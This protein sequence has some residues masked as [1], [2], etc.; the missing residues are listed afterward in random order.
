[1]NSQ[2]EVGASKNNNAERTVQSFSVTLNNHM[3]FYA[4]R[5]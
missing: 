4:L 3:D 2:Y 5:A 1:M